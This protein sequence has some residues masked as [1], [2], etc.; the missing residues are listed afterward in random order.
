MRR[1][2]SNTSC[3]MDSDLSSLVKDRHQTHVPLLARLQHQPSRLK[4]SASKRQSRV[5]QSR[6]LPTHR[7]ARSRSSKTSSTPL[8]L[9]EMIASRKLISSGALR[10]T[11]S[12]KLDEKPSRPRT[13][14]SPHLLPIAGRAPLTPVERQ[15][16]QC[17]KP[18]PVTSPTCQL[19]TKYASKLLRSVTRRLARAV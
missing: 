2:W 16:P 19:R 14:P 5:D 9:K 8:V 3:K 10:N 17:R 11:R 7:V 4:L 18:Q 1:I 6:F 12:R 13:A 15:V